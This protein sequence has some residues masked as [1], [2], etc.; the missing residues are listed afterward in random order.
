MGGVSAALTQRKT[1]LQAGISLR[2]QQEEMGWYLPFY[3]WTSA[4]IFHCWSFFFNYLFSQVWKLK[5]ELMC[6]GLQTIDSEVSL[7]YIYRNILIFIRD[8]SH[9]VLVIAL[10]KTHWS[11][12]FKVNLES[13]VKPNLCV[14]ERGRTLMGKLCN[15]GTIFEWPF[16]HFLASH[17]SWL[18]GFFTNL[19]LI[20]LSQQIWWPHEVYILRQQVLERFVITG[21]PLKAV[22]TVC[23][24]TARSKKILGLNPSAGAGTFLPFCGELCMFSLSAW[25]FWHPQP[26]DMEV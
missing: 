15:D 9:W 22:S 11:K 14:R 24:L 12:T 6:L 3:P 16:K 17:V 26:K 18:Y 25:V 7:K 8:V 23:V 2:A 19:V 10:T 1:A 20:W 13:E 21:D 5:I 4:T